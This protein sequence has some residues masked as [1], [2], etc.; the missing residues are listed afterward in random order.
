LATLGF[1]NQTHRM[2]KQIEKIRGEMQL[3]IRETHM[4]NVLEIISKYLEHRRKC[5]LEYHSSEYL[6][7]ELGANNTLLNHCPSSLD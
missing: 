1:F 4:E 5:T 2:T 3:S 7:L 6:I